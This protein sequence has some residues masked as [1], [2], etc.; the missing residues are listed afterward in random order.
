MSL[1]ITLI[2]YLD[3]QIAAGLSTARLQDVFRYV[4]AIE[5]VDPTEVAQYLYEHVQADAGLRGAV[6]LALLHSLTDEASPVMP[7]DMDARIRQRLFGQRAPVDP[8]APPVQGRDQPEMVTINTPW[9]AIIYNKVTAFQ[10]AWEDAP[11]LRDRAA[12][13]RSMILWR[14]IERIKHLDFTALEE[15]QAEHEQQAF[16]AEFVDQLRLCREQLL[17]MADGIDRLVAVEER[18]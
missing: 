7:A 14:A 4:G 10:R 11:R 12:A 9:D 13:R 6:R 2:A 16:D 15:L 1:S 8:P 5:G 3:D 17:K 18:G